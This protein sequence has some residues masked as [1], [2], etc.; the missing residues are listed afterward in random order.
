M[1]RPRVIGDY[2]ATQQIGAGSFA[3]VWKAYHKQQPNFHLAIKE[4][5][6]ERLNK[7]LQES[8]RSE[9]AILRRT[10]HPNII[11][12]H[13]IV[14]APNRIY[15]VLEYCAGGDLAA[16]I[17]RYGKVSE[18]TARHFMQ[19][20]GAG[21]QVLRNNNLIHRDLKPQNLLLSTDDNTAVLK[22]A[23]FGFARLLQ[24]QGMA[25]TLCGSPLYM[26]PEILQSKKYD[27]KADLWSVGAIL[28]QLV[29][30]RPPFSGNNHL[31]LLQNIMKT[32]EVQFPE[33]LMAE[34]HP[35]CIDMCRKLL[36]PNPVE[37]LS[38]EEFFSHSFMESLRQVFS[39]LHLIDLPKSGR[40]ND[41]QATSSNSAATGDASENSQ[42]EFFPFL[43]DDVQ[44]GVVDGAAS[45]S[46]PPLFSASPS[47]SLLLPP[48]GRSR[49]S[50]GTSPP[51]RLGLAS[52]DHCDDKS[53]GALVDSIETLEREYVVVT[54]DNLMMS[55]SAS[56][57]GQYPGKETGGSPQ[58]IAYSPYMATTGSGGG[59]GS[60]G[61]NASVP[62]HSS[63]DSVGDRLEGPSL[64][65][66]TRL[67][68]LKRCAQLVSNVAND[69]FEARHVLESVSIQLVCLAI[70]K[71]ALRVCQAWAEA[72][73]GG[74]RNF[75][76]SEAGSDE[77]SAVNACSLMEREFT[78]A[79]E[80][81]EFLALHLSTIDAGAAMPDAME[82]IFQTALAVARA[83]AVD[84]LMGNSSNAAVAYSKA[85][86][87]LYFL[88]VEAAYL[89]IQPPLLLSPMDRHRLRRYADAV[90]ARQHQ[91]T[92]AASGGAHQDE[93]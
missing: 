51:S 25:E 5:V 58:K 59:V 80:R 44:Q 16:Y 20:L 50:L 48:T 12:L 33:P 89:P 38:F 61:S 11:R 24:P 70:W 62:S 81:A 78:S 84:E 60:G 32:N 91:C 31:Q 88:V 75:G 17:Q 2:V 30:G 82:L 6:T 13:D 42:E 76:V 53:K 49:T 29:T 28:Y 54:A 93:L 18:G 1:A 57:V 63:Q 56:G 43:L 36:R 85:A 83:G 4:I 55:L 86:S 34:L 79:V 21:L 92:A 14:E 15:L 19:Q 39:S 45:L 9:I 8:L 74:G 40:S 52:R 90:T 26:A 77:V 10:D 68:S 47:S 41:L 64:H 67:S 46:K 72:V 71:E 65:P 35:D 7:K 73:G 87:L 22:I 27:A 66:P 3:V 69:K 37:R 23:D